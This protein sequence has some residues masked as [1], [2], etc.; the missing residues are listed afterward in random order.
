[1]RSFSSLYERAAERKGGAVALE[2]L[3]PT[4]LGVDEL[5]AISDDRWLAMMSKTIFQAGFRWSV[6]DNKWPGFEAAFAGFS[7]QRWKFMS[8]DDF[9][10]LI[11][12]SRII[13][14][15]TKIFAV[16]DNATFLCDLAEAH[17]SA[18]HFFAHW[19]D[20]DFA[21]LLILLK[22]RG[23]RLGGH[24]AQ[25]FLRFMGKDSFIMSAD[26]VTALK[27]EQIISGDPKSQRDLKA[28]QRA[29]NQWHEES[30]RSLTHISKVLAFTV[31]A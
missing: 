16:R 21:A 5:S 13:R 3:L 27:R 6:V 18:A 15:A 25:Y 31:G 4:P 22:K 12:D 1:M 23:C 26:V 10:K 20:D 17:G 14:N 24:S 19:P 28:V 9:E 30:S 29:F 2:A 11:K 8:E 7:P